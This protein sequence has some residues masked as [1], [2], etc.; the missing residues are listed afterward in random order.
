ML[1]LR[2]YAPGGCCQVTGAG[3]ACGVRP[4]H[5]PDGGGGSASNVAVT[6][7]SARR[8]IEHELPLHAPPNPV[9]RQPASGL[10]VRVIKVPSSNAAQQVE[11][12]SIPAGDELTAPCPVR[13]TLSACLPGGGGG[14]LAN[15]AVTVRSVSSK[16]SQATA[17]LQEPPHPEK[18]APASGAAPSCT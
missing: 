15:V 6:L 12:Q 14:A 13:A 16:T 17:P 9:N 4:S 10:G 18:T 2:E 5:E 8:V 3:T 7:A 1:L 11:P